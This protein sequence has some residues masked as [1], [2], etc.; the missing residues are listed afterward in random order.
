MGG[1]HGFGA[2]PIEMDEPIYHEAWEGRVAAITRRLMANSTIDRFR[3]TIEQMPPAQYLSSRYYER[4]LWAA[5][6]LSTDPDIL[7]GMQRAGSSTAP[8]GEPA[9]PPRFAA[10]QIVRVG[11][12]VTPGHTRVPRY[13]RNHE[14]TVVQRSCAWPHPTDSAATGRYGPTEHVYAVAF[15]GRDVFGPDAD[16]VVV[17]DVWERDLEE[18]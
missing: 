14:G 17:V 16:H 15:A 11:N 8:P 9:T 3:Y 5:E 4:W 10:G 12:P 13:I 6:R 1:M 7:A 2:V 18:A